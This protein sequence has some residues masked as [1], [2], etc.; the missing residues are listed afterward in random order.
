MYFL[1][2]GL[3]FICL[4]SISCNI[5]KE[6]STASNLKQQAKEE[7]L[8]PIR[9][10]NPDQ[11]PFWN[12]KARRFINVPAFDFKELKKAKS[13]KFT[14]T[15]E[16]DQKTYTFTA[17]EP[18]AVLAPIWEKL[19]VG[20]VHLVVQ[21]IDNN[22]DTTGIAGERRFYRAAVF[23]GP[24]QREKV[25]YRYHAIKQL[26]TLFNT[27]HIQRWANEGTPDHDAYTLYAY[28]SKI[29]SAVAWSMILYAKI[30]P[31]HKDQAIKIAK[32]AIDYLIQSSEPVGAPYAFF[33]QTYEGSKV[34]AERFQG[35]LMMC[36]PAR[37]AMV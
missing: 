10:G 15:S 26:E 20:Y 33:P 19:P 35:Q 1:K 27:D 34:A 28:P 17:Q 25:D 14:A 31:E 18:W 23:N 5:K 36:Y 24:S 16:A 6:S 3:L 12:E 32:G 22:G 11:S 9:P 7:S 4:C 13:Y 2:Y 8:I 21:G 29:V 30:S 37:A